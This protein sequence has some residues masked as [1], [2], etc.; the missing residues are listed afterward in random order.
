MMNNQL[1]ALE[2]YYDKQDE[3]T[4]ECLL[5]LKHLIL[6]VDNEIIHTRKY[7]IP[8]FYYKDLKLA[9]LWVYRKRIMLGFVEDRKTL[10]T[11]GNHKRKDNIS[12]LE[13]KPADELPFDQIR[14]ELILL[15]SAYKRG[16]SK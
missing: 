9:F 11:S 1:T 7:R 6:S 10:I 16:L 12:T 8:F 13:F 4:R 14:Q 15:I 3:M 2:H 5:A